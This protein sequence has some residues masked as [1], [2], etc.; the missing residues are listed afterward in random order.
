MYGFEPVIVPP[1]ELDGPTRRTV[2]DAPVSLASSVAAEN[3][4]G[5]PAVLPSESVPA[6]GHVSLSGAGGIVH[7]EP[8]VK[9]GA[10]SCAGTASGA[11]SAPT[12]RAEARAAIQRTGD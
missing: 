12:R 11:V 3:V 2:S 8:G 4:T 10:R 7:V 5:A 6:R 9:N 1:A